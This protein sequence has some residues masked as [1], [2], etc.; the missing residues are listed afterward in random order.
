MVLVAVSTNV[1]PDTA[2]LH[3][4]QRFEPLPTSAPS[5]SGSEGAACRARA[6]DRA[7][8]RGSST[9]PHDGL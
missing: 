4:G 1:G 2:R 9:G 5:A 3:S 6:K 8:S 7:S